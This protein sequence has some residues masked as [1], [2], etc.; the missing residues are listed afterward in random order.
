MA[1]NA[2]RNTALFVLMVIVFGAATLKLTAE[3]KTAEQ[4]PRKAEA[5]KRAPTLSENLVA[6]EQ[7]IHRQV[8]AYRRSRGVSNAELA[9]D[10][11][12][13]FAASIYADYAAQR[14]KLSQHQIPGQ[15]N[16]YWPS[17]RVEHSG[18]NAGY[19][20]ENAVESFPFGIRDPKAVAAELISAWKGSP[21]HHRA[22]V[23]PKPIE[24]GISIRYNANTRR[25]YGVQVF[26]SPL[27]RSGT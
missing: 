25:Y 11:Q 16:L 20:S 26:A 7:E 12:L 5:V 3:E 15:R 6:I 4:N 1:R 22:M 17:D 8:N 10:H 27:Y 19:T 9:W 23:S 24:T 13:E 18:Y 2:L 14:G 21:G